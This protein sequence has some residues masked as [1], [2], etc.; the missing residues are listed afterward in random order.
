MNYQASYSIC[1]Q[2]G[3][4]HDDDE[5][6]LFDLVVQLKDGNEKLRRETSYDDAVDLAHKH[7]KYHGFNKYLVNDRVFDATSL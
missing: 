5:T 4:S 6:P 7:A 1:Q 2:S 3:G